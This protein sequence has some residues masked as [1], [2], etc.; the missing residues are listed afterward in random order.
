MSEAI[1]LQS[2]VIQGKED[3]AN[4]LILGGRSFPAICWAW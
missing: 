1:R 2:K 3:G 4:L